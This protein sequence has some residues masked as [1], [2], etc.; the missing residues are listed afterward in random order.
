M[1]KQLKKRSVNRFI[2]KALVVKGLEVRVC[3]V[4]FRV[5]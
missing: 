1:N 3:V 4:C 2:Y 5:H